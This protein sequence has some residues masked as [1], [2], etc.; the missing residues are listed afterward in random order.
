LL[1][2][3]LLLQALLAGAAA[4]LPV[5]LFVEPAAVPALAVVAAGATLLHL[6]LLAGEVTM[7]HGTAHANLAVREMTS[8]RY[9]SFFRAG[10]LLQALGVALLLFGPAPLGALLA[11]AGL[12]AYE[13]AYVQAG[14]SVPLA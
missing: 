7:S 2:P 10:T 14:Q 4:L 11:L 8:G 12:L 5:A 9:A 1:P 6:L 3:M 13:H